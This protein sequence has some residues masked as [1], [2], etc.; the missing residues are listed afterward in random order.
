MVDQKQDHL[1]LRLATLEV[2]TISA[3]NLAQINAISFLT[4]SS[5]LLETTPKNEV[6]K[7]I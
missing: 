7:F 5:N 4:L 2:L 3:P 6:A 1:I